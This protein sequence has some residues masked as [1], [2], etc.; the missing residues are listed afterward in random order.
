MAY[1][2]QATLAADQAFRDKVRVALATA[3]VAVMGEAVGEYSDTEF[4]KRQAL[5]HSVLTSAASGMWL[6]AFVWGTVANVAITS[7]SLD[8]D[9][10][11]TVDALWGDMAGVRITD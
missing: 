7:E 11:F 5:A 2:A 9:I 4:G 3:A 10:Q 1:T 8:S 6:E